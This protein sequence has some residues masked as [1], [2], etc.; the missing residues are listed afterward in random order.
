MMVNLWYIT[1]GKFYNQSK[2]SFTSWEINLISTVEVEDRMGIIFCA[3][4]Y[5]FWND[6]FCWC[7]VWFGNFFTEGMLKLP[8][9]WFGVFISWHNI[10]TYILYSLLIS[11]PDCHLIL[12]NGQLK[13]I[14]TCI[15]L[16]M[17]LICFIDVGEKLW[18][19]LMWFSFLSSNTRVLARSS[20][21]LYV[22]SSRCL[23]RISNEEE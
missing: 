7:L 2:T 3:H 19:G 10:N 16:F 17:S 22:S 11:F 1:L 21:C 6:F 18:W 5:Y 14:C 15:L 8:Q 13:Y 20:V 4:I 23:Y 12:P 9:W